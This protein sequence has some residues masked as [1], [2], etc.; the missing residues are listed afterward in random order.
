MQALLRGWL[1][2]VIA[3]AAIAAAASG[4]AARSQA[5]KLPSKAYAGQ[6]RLVFAQAEQDDPDPEGDPDADP[7]V[8][9][10]SLER[11]G[12]AATAREARESL[13]AAALP[14]PKIWT[15]LVVLILLLRARLSRKLVRHGQPFPT[16]TESNEF[17]RPAA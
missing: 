12:P 11:Y 9:A 3:I 5:N 14:D 1:V 16:Q 13:I 15:F 8:A 7:D 6:Q 4:S 10:L 2:V 17:I